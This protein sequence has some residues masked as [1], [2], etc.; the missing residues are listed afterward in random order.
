MFYTLQTAQKN[1]P[2]VMLSELRARNLLV[3]GCALSE[4]LA[5]FFIRFAGKSRLADGMRKRDFL[6]DPQIAEER[7][8]AVFLERFSQNTHVFAQTGPAFVRELARRWR[9]RH[10]DDSRYR[11]TA[12]EIGTSATAAEPDIFISYS[13]TDLPAA[14][15]LCED[16]KQRGFGVA[17]FDKSAL[18]PGDAWEDRVKSAIQ[19]LQVLPAPALGLDGAARRRILPLGMEGGGDA[20]GPDPG[21]TVPLPGRHRS[22]V[23]RQG[24]PLPARPAPVPRGTIR[25]CSRRAG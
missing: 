13:R 5:R 20:L 22:G 23:R 9:E 1:V 6:I 2:R 8:L 7:G 11:A 16:L 14:K 18:K 12:Q 25:P 21:R 17:W 4:W 19:N 3:I 10:A 15:V 24:E